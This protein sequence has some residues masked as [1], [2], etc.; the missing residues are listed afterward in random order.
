MIPVTSEGKDQRDREGLLGLRDAPGS[1]YPGH[2]ICPGPLETR[3]TPAKLDSLV[4]QETLA[5]LALLD[6]QGGRVFLDL[7]ANWAGRDLPVPPGSLAIL[8]LLVSQG[9][10]ENK[11]SPVESA[12]PESPAALAAA[13]ASATPW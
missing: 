8:D 9:L 12:A 7:P 11:V 13:P 3:A 2:S 5:I 4:L 1:L 6:A 10:L